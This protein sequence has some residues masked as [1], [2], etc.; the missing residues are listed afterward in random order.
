[1]LAAALALGACTATP[2]PA[3]S[4]QPSPAQPEQ[5]VPAGYYRQAKDGELCKKVDLAPLTAVV[6]GMAVGSSTGV[7]QGNLRCDYTATA[8]S[9]VN[10]NIW[11]TMHDSADK[12]RKVFEDAMNHSPG[13][14]PVTLPVSKFAAIA[15]TTGD[16]ISVLDQN[17]LA[18]AGTYAADKTLITEKYAA[19]VHRIFDALLTLVRRELQATTGPSASAPP[20]AARKVTSPDA[21]RGRQR[22]A[23]NRWF[24]IT[25]SL[26]ESLRGL[27]KDPPVKSAYGSTSA[28]NVMIFAATLNVKANAAETVL[29]TLASEGITWS[30]PA[31][32]KMPDGAEI[33]CGDGKIKDQT[34]AVC[35]WYD[36]YSLGVAVFPGQKPADTK[37]DFIALRELATRG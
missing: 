19:A 5:Q 33:R 20:A 4:A 7:S 25:F 17:L 35:L 27:D 16:G 28:G 1:M 37:A 12:A 2:E 29:A 6:P 14:R 13:G 18:G 23:D 24:E 15:A 21:V 11:L 8:P 31:A 32:E 9:L 10:L 3:P 30:N 34:G 36:Q 22:N 26:G